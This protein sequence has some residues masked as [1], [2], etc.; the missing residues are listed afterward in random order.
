M[1]DAALRAILRRPFAEQVAAFRL[2]LGNLVP[3]SRWDDLWQVQHDRAFMVAGATKA[4]LL[5][6][7][8]RAVDRAISEGTGLDA[9]RHDFREIVTRHGWHGWTGEGTEA[10]EAWRTKVIYRTNMRTSYMACG[11]AQL[12]AGNFKYWVYLHSGA[13]HPR[14]Q[15]LAWNGIALPPEHSFWQVAYPPNGWGCGCEVFGTNSEAG[16][17]RLGGDPDKVLPD[18]WDRIDPKT[19]TPQGIDK[20]WA[21]APGASATANIRRAIDAKLDRLPPA[22]ASDLRATTA[23]RAAARSDG[24]AEILKAIEHLNEYATVYPIA[25][26]RLAVRADR[27][28]ALTEVEQLALRAYSSPGLYQP[29]NARMRGGDDPFGESLDVFGRAVSQALSKLPAHRGR[30]YRGIEDSADLQRKFEAMR[31]GEVVKFRAFTSAS[32]TIET[33]LAGDTLLE[34]ESLSGRT[35]SRASV[36]PQELEVLFDRGRVFEVVSIGET[37]HWGY[38]ALKVVLREIISAGSRAVVL[39]SEVAR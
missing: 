15:H 23:R 37:R 3:T 5:A 6:D 33:T 16:V 31:P 34:I 39:M 18:G 30:V 36:M 19:G 38:A 35:I 27:I 2:R 24:D 1:T 7:L 8:G 13:E 25:D 11:H 29:L 28:A 4:D 22:I 32:E 10:G 26:L 14:L 21:Y 20:G 9:F 17:R 12:V